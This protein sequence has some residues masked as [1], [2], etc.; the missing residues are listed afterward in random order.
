MQELSAIFDQID[1]D[2][3]GAISLSELDHALNQ[4]NNAHFGKIQL[5]AMMK[6]ADV[7]HDG[8]ISREEFL[9]LCEELQ[10]STHIPTLPKITLP[11]PLD[12][13]KKDGK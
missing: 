13:N 11:N 4:S 8:M 6:K 12:G 10:T 9:N 5:K 1:E 2:K 3:S 7:N